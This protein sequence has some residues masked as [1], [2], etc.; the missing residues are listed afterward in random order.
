MFFLAGAI[1]EIT[2]MD[3]VYHGYGV[4]RHFLP[5]VTKENHS[6]ILAVSFI[7]GGNKSTG[8]QPETCHKS[9]TNFITQCCIEYTS[10][11]RD[12]SNSQR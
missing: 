10:P 8:R 9:L 4:Y 12:Y 6:Y 2:H 7:G 11:E 1:I 3:G 5:V